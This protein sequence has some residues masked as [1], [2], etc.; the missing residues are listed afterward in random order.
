[1]HHVMSFNECTDRFLQHYDSCISRISLTTSFHHKNLKYRSCLSV[2]DSFPRGGA[3]EFP[4]NNRSTT[5]WTQEF[6]QFFFNHPKKCW[7]A[8]FQHH[9][10]LMKR[11]MLGQEEAGTEGFKYLLSMK[12][13][14]LTENKVQDWEVQ[15][16]FLDVFGGCVT[17]ILSDIFQYG[18]FT[19]PIK[20]I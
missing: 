3:G 4:Y 13:W 8:N 1:M 16:T 14:S 17:S 18:G 12:M 10:M 20:P 9:G 5:A 19:T 11:C 6:S 7:Q 15:R 2:F